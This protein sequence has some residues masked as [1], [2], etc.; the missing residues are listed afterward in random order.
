MDGTNKQLSANLDDSLPCHCDSPIVSTVVDHEQLKKGKFKIGVTKL[1]LK[2]CFLNIN[3]SFRQ[4]RVSKI[5]CTSNP[6]YATI[7]PRRITVDT[8]INVFSAVE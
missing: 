4:K 5:T 6:W 8:D 3:F 7:S 1:V 2:L